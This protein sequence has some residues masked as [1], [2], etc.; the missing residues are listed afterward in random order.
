[1]R[2][3][4]SI[5]LSMSAVCMMANGVNAQIHDEAA[6]WNSGSV[7]AAGLRCESSGFMD[8]GQTTVVMALSVQRLPSSYAQQVRN[9]YEEGLRRSAIYSKNAARWIPVSI[10]QETCKQVDYA[11]K[12][13]KIAF[14]TIEKERDHLGLT[15]DTRSQFVATVAGSC[16]RKHEGEPLPLPTS[17]VAEF[18][19]CYANAIA[20]RVSASELAAQDRMSTSDQDIAMRPI[21]QA[22]GKACISVVRR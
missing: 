13:Y 8:Q 5:L 15:G 19:R 11:V 12:Q 14:D 22:A 2:A 4:R 18:C 9:G 6:A 21:V 20:D 16:L 7:F 3:L 1:M 17:T 10:S